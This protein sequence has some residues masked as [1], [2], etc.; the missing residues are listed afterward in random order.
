MGRP[1]YWSS[2]ELILSPNVTRKC[3]KWLRLDEAIYLLSQYLD[4][5]KTLQHLENNI[6]RVIT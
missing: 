5:P 6:R 2:L 4:I 1:I 3:D